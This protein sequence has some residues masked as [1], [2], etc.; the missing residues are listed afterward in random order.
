[1]SIKVFQ[2]VMCGADLKKQFLTA[3]AVKCLSRS[4]HIQLVS[5]TIF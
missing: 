5:R 3:D 1:M 4:S 2:D